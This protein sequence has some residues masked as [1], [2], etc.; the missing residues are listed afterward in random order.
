MFKSPLVLGINVRG[1]LN[2]GF[3]VE[4]C[5]SVAGNNTGNLIFSESLF[6][7]IRNGVISSYHFT[8]EVAKGRDAVVVAAANWLNPHSDFGVLAERLEALKL[9]VILVGLGA[10]PSRGREHPTLKPG[11]ERLVR[12]AA[13]SSKMISVRGPFS[14]EV[15]NG[16]GVKNVEVTGC[17]S[18]LLASY[19]RGPLSK[20]SKNPQ[21]V[22]FHSTRHLMHDTSPL[23]DYFYKEAYRQR[24][25]IVLQSE[26]AD[27]YYAL[28]RTVNKEIMAKVDPIVCK[29]YG[30]SDAEAVGR[31]L[32]LHGKVFYDL[33]KWTDYAQTQDLFVG[34]RIHGTVAALLAGTP[35]ILMTHDA[36]T[37]ELAQTLNIPFVPAES[38][39]MTRS[40]D[41]P[42]LIEQA[43]FSRFEARYGAYLRTFTAFFKSNGLEMREEQEIMA[44]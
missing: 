30:D 21:R 33:E 34:T 38:V 20:V 43:D 14:A 31:Y 25:D 15:L 3:T 11:T 5:L 18:L 1:V 42:A 12:L 19:A 16:F 6:R 28:G 26:L 13:E 23:Q 10:Q 36:R 37:V 24:Y 7:V 35:G 9:P 27:F 44:A 4:K 8:P 41:L 40:L 39:D 29:S 22:A 17:P 32:R 2:N